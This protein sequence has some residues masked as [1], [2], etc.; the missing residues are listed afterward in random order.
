M[1]YGWLWCCGT[2]A[3]CS[4]GI[5]GGWGG[6]ELLDVQMRKDAGA[7]EVRVA[8]LTAVRDQRWGAVR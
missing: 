7:R 2:V 6:G 4:A 1:W 8:A 5:G 3:V